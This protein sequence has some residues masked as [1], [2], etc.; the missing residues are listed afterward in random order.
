MK[1]NAFTLVELLL[2]IAIIVAILGI[3]IPAFIS[4]SRGQALRNAPAKV[5]SAVYLA[6]QLT[7]N[8]KVLHRI[9]FFKDRMFFWRETGG[10]LDGDMQPINVDSLTRLGTEELKNAIQKYGIA[11]GKGITCELGYKPMDN[12]S[13]SYNIDNSAE[14]LENLQK[15]PRQLEEYSIGFKFDGSVNFFGFTSLPYAALNVDDPEKPPEKADIV[16]SQTGNAEKC[17]VDVDQAGGR[18][19]SRICEPAS[20]NKKSGK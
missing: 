15:S 3:S 1:R 17:F 8:R 12:S 7:T 4:M 19:R 2:V 13:L 18:I 5:Q 9:V 16:F 11:Y 10:F 20:D 14:V 6:R